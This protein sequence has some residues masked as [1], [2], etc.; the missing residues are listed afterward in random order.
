MERK[1]GWIKAGRVKFFWAVLVV[2]LSTAPALEAVVIIQIDEIASIPGDYGS[3]ISDDLWVFGE[4]NIL[5][6]ALIE[7]GVA[8]TPTSVVNIAS[9]T[10]E[11]LIEVVG[12][13]EVESGAEVTVYGTNFK[14]NGADASG[15]IPI[16]GLL[17]GIYENGTQINLNIF[18]QSGATVTLVT[19]VPPEPEDPAD[20][21]LQLIITVA[22]LNLHQGIDNSLDA[23]LDAAWNALDDVNA[24]NDVAAINTI[25]AFINAVEAQRD[26]K[27]TSEQADTLV[28]DSQVI[29]DLLS[30][31]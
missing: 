9:G 17:T 1:E 31:Q 11:G 25:Q 15:T 10:V 13:I 12:S 3:T 18:C 19:L 16:V 7:G 30:A 23:K 20:L 22:D 4:L 28:A 14:V 29:I 26:N 27:I 6:T 8:A 2:L 24:N 5:P 21:I